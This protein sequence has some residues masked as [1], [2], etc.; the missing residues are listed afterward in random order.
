MDIYLA[1][2]EERKGPYSKSSL[3]EFFADDVLDGTELAWHEGLTKWVPLSQINGI[4]LQEASHATSPLHGPTQM[5]PNNPK[6]KVVVETAIRM[7]AEKPIGELTKVDLEKVEKLNL[8]NNKISDLSALAKLTRLT[9]LH[10]GFNQISD[11]SALNELKQLKN[12][13]L[14]SNQISDVSALKEL[15]HLT[16]LNLSENK[17]NDVNPLGEL[18]RLTTLNLGFNRISDVSILVELHQLT[19]LH[20]EDNPNLTKAQIAE[21]QKVLP[22]CDIIHN[23][24]R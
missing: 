3:R 23:T 6:A 5:V 1:K 2:G 19:R 18:K 9:D 21:L 16:G 20:L 4:V 15:T 13:T 7:A 14:Y 17:I 24:K 12:L 22:K 8:S 11:L 10:L